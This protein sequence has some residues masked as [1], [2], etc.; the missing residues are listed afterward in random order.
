[1]HNHDYPEPL[2][3]GA[4]YELYVEI[5]PTSLILPACYRLTLDVQGHDYVYPGAVAAQPGLATPFTGSGPF[6]HNDTHARPADV[7]ASTVTVHT[8][9]AHPSHLLMPVVKANHG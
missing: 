4:I 7:D 5:W 2:T 6:L 9:P 8:G 1:V 3:P